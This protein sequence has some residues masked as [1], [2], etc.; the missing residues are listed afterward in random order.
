LYVSEYNAGDILEFTPSGDKS[1]F[2]SGLINPRYM[3]FAPVPEPSTL[4]L[5]GLGALIS[6][7]PFRLKES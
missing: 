2:V 3:A 7:A 6:L 4:A 1:T 5:A